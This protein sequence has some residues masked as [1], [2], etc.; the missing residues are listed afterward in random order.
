MAWNEKNGGNPWN[1]GGKQGPPDLDKVVRD[2]QR[3]LGGIF[4]G[5]GGSGASSGKAGGAGIGVIIAIVVVLWSLS[6]IYKVDDAERGVVTQFGRYHSTTPPGL[7][8]HIPFPIQKV[9]TVN[10]AIVD[11]YKHQTRMLTADE[12]LVLVDTV[13][14]FRRADPIAYLFNIRDPESTLA[15]VSESAIREIVGSATLDFVVTE[16]R[17][18][19]ADRTKELIQNTLDDY[20]SGLVVTSVNLQDAN[21]PPQV[22]ASVEDAIKA[23]EDRER[24]ALEAQSYANDI[25]PRARGNAARQVLD[26]EAYSARVVADARGEAARFE[27]LLTEYTKAPEVTRE[28]LYIETVESVYGVTNKVLLDAEGSG[29]LLYLPMDELMRR[30]NKAMI[31]EPSPVDTGPG[32]G[33]GGSDVPRSRTGEDLRSRG[34]RR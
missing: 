29:N 5:R 19:I 13:V 30:Q 6:G 33:G 24:L 10:V 23:R 8:W 1:D 32:S 11:S 21:F 12:N 25:V 31:R 20:G 18:D 22:Q 3:K 2:L 34:D 28:R 15:E 16:G 4:G 9:D 7:H 26:A 27:A 14:Q 17:E